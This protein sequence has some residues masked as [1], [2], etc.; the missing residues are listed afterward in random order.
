[1][2][3][4]QAAKVEGSAAFPVASDHKYPID[5]GEGS[6]ATNLKPQSTVGNK[7]KRG[8]F[9][10][11]EILLL[12]NMSNVVRDVDSALRETGAGHVD[13][14]LYLAVMEMGGF[15]T[16][17]LIVAYTYL[18]ENKAIATGFEDAGQP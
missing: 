5:V 17:A 13:P 11:D 14:D 8:N 12:T 9:T 6:K 2:A 18:L 15:S 1:M 16:E 3:N 7:R 10:E 4:S